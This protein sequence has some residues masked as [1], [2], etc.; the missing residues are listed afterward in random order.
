MFRKRK[1]CLLCSISCC[2]VGNCVTVARLES[3]C[4]HVPPNCEEISIHVYTAAIALLV[5][6]RSS[7]SPLR[8]PNREDASKRKRTMEPNDTITDDVLILTARGRGEIV[9]Q[10]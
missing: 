8:F 6:R 1:E 2:L 4:Q 5:S 10:Y 9:D 3:Q 7:L